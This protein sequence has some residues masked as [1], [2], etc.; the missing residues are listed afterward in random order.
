MRENGDLEYTIQT[1]E[2]YGVWSVAGENPSL[3]YRIVRYNRAHGMKN[4][5]FRTLRPGDPLL[6]PADAAAEFETNYHGRS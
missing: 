1:K 4:G 5:D 2:V 3:W 6:I